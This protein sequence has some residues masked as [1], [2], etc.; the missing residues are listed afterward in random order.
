[1]LIKYS[2][3]SGN[4]NNLLLLNMGRTH[5]RKNGIKLPVDEILEYNAKY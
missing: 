5:S 1:M 4:F 3:S 2:F